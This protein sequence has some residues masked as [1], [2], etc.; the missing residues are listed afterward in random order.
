MVAALLFG[1][2]PTGT[3]YALGGFG[4]VT[5][6]VVE[7]L[8]ATIVLW[9]ALLCNGYRRP[10]C[11][12]RVL[13]LG[14]LEPGLACLLFDFG[15]DRTTASNAALITGLECGFVVVLAALFLRERVGWAVI[16][17]AALAVIGL[18]VL[19]GASSFGAPGV[20]DLLV[21]AGVLSAAIYTIVARGLPSQG[22]SL[23]ITA[24]QFV[25]ATV[26]VLP[27]AV[28][29]WTDAA[30]PLPLDVAPRF[31]IVAVL[32]G[33]LGGAVAFLLYNSAIV[34]VS[35]GA[36][37]V[38][39]NLAP[40]FGLASAVLL[41]DETLT[42]ERIL[43]AML[44][45]L[46]VALFLWFEWA[47]SARRRRFRTSATGSRGDPDQAVSPFGSISF[48]ATRSALFYRR[49]RTDLRR[50]R[51][52]RRPSGRAPAS[53]PAMVATSSTRAARSASRPSGP[54]G[55]ALSTT[56]CSGS[57]PAPTIP[58]RPAATAVANG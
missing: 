23:A 34:H 16:T 35:A 6:L 44:I 25:A 53:S 7:L 19:E 31:W 41:L 57:E 47:G 18:L 1:I 27:L 52:L 33:T 5:V 30:E 32:V 49:V 3:K 45:G 8:A 22:G 15:L 37:G 12:R 17:A 39:I 14:L 9:L 26:V 54:T 4:P 43:G 42:K 56:I 29:R 20:G 11:W 21:A 46:S 48:A 28:L 50:P 58:G 24:L 10:R 2:A 55:I 51:R 36:A 13:V 40:A 38:I